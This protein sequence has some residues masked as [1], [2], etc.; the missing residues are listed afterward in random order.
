MGFFASSGILNQ[1][2]FFSAPASAAPP[3]FSPTDISG[4]KLWLKADAGVTYDGSNRVSAWADQSGQGNNASASGDERPVYSASGLN[5]KP[6]ISFNGSAQVLTITDN[7]SLDFSTMSAYLVIK[8]DDDGGQ[9]DVV[10]IKNG[11]STSDAAVYGIVLFSDA[12]NWVVGMDKG[13]GWGDNFTDFDVSDN[14]PKIIGYR[15]N[16][17]NLFAH[18][19]G[20]LSSDLGGGTIPSTNGTLQIGGYNQSFDNPSGE[21]F[22]GKIS[23]VIFYDTSLSSGNH[24]SVLGYLNGRYAIY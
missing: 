4:L 13:G 8:R 12:T 6:T 21:W 11:S 19:N 3:A 7:A 5:S 1:R 17:S 2:G 22:F 16:S 18:Q 9:N 20:S 14:L 15:V 24:A 10:F 23:E